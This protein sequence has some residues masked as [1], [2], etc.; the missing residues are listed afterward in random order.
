M[1]VFTQYDRLVKMKEA[2]LQEVYPH[3][4]LHLRDRVVEESQEAFTNCFQSFQ[5]TINSLG[6]PM[7]PYA[8]VSG[9]TY[10]VVLYL[11]LTI[12]SSSRSSGTCFEACG[13]D[14]EYC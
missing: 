3:V 6:I 10:A 5:H 12:T 9:N 4:D 11:L 8:R 1:I 7:P 14:Y 13:S 2:E